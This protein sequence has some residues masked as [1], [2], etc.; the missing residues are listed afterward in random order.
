MGL[1]ERKKQKA[2]HDLEKAA[3]RLFD[4]KGFDQTTIKEIAAAAEMS[5]R[6]FFRY[7]ESKEEVIFFHAEEDTQVLLK[8]LK[9]RPQDEKEYESLRGAMLEWANYLEEHRD[10]IAFRGRLIN[11]AA[12]PRRRAAE[13]REEAA[14]SMA[15]V[16]R[17]KSGTEDPS[18][19]VLLA[20]V[21]MEVISIALF[22]WSFSNFDR[23]LRDHVAEAFQEL[24]DVIKA[25][26][27]ANAGR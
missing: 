6:T 12:G 15:D 1:R 25:S 8:C 14:R 11:E 3:L 22:R 16:L 26:S 7:F 13:L 23:R 27:G 9:E 20:S 10:L 2:R 19:N 24:Q 5:P 21:S 4:E 17:A 18:G